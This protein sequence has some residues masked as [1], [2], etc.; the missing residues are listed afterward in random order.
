M[1]PL[2]RISVAI[3]CGWL[4]AIQAMAAQT[5]RVGVYDN[6]PI[7]FRVNENQYAGIGIDVLTD[8]ARQNDWKLEYHYGPWNEVLHLL[9]SG[10][11]DLLI[12][13]AYTPERAKRFNFISE[14]LVNN[15]GVVYQTPGLNLTAMS[16][17]AGKR[18]ALM[19]NSIH[20]QRF[21]ELMHQFGFEY[22]PVLVGHYKDVF[23]AIDQGEAN[24]GVVNRI[25]SI[26]DQ[27]YYD[28]KPTSIMFNPVQVRIAA[29]GQ[30]ESPYLPKINNYLV[31]A[32]SNSDSYYYRVLQN[33]MEKSREEKLPTWLWIVL[34]VAIATLFFVT[35]YSLLVKRQVQLRTREL[36]EVESRFRQLSESVDA[37]FWISSP[38]WHEIFYVSPGYQKIWGVKPE[39]LYKNPDS[40][41]KQIHEQDRSKVQS[42]VQEM[43]NRIT[44]GFTLPEYRVIHRDG[45][46]RWVLAKV[47][48]VHD[49]EGKIIRLAGIC[50]DIT[51]RKQ[52]ADALEYSRTVLKFKNEVLNTVNT[53]ADRVYQS[54]S[55]QD[56]ARA[57]VDSLLQY[58]HSP[59][60]TFY[61]INKE[62]QTLELVH[63]KGFDES[64]LKDAEIIPIDG[65]FSGLCASLK[66]I[67]LSSDITSDQRVDA[68]VKQHLVR[69]GYQSIV[70]VPLLF[71]DEVFGVI[72][73]VF[74]D[75]HQLSRDES[76][77]LMTLGKSVGLAL[78]NTRH[79]QQLVDEK[80]AR[81]KAEQVLID[82][83]KGISTKSGDDFYKALIQQLAAAYNM[84]YAYIG[85]LNENY[86]KVRTIGNVLDGKLIDDFEYALENTPCQKV[87]GED[88]CIYSGNVQQ[89]FP[90]AK[91]LVETGVNSYIG[92]PLINSTGEPLGIIA[93]MDDEVFTNIDQLRNVVIIF[94]YRAASELERQNS[95]R[96]LRESENRYRT[97]IENAPEAIT[98]FNIDRGKFTD[99]NKNAEIF[100]GYD[101]KTLLELN[102][103]EL[104]PKQQPNGKDSSELAHKYITSALHGEVP[105]FEWVHLNSEDKPVNCEIRLVRLPSTQVNEVRGSITDITER[106][107][108]EAALKLS[109]E[110]FER[111]VSGSSDGFWDWPDVSKPDIWWSPRM[112]EM[113]GYQNNE[114]QPT[115]NYFEENLHPEDY[116]RIMKSIQDH[117]QHN[118]PYDVEFR[119]RTR[120]GDYHWY[121]ARGQSLKDETSK[122]ERMSGSMQDVTS[123]KYA[124]QALR[125]SEAR[126]RAIF[127]D[128]GVGIA[129]INSKGELLNCNPAALRI[130]GY[131]EREL[132]NN[133]FA[134]ITHPDDLQKNASRFQQ[135][136]DEEL[137]SY[138]LE[139]RYIRKDKSV[140]EA[141]LI[142]TSIR[143]TERKFRFAIAMI[144]D[145]S[146]RKQSERERM[147]S[148]RRLEA[149][150][151]I[152]EAILKARSPIQTARAA[153]Q[154]LQQLID[155][156]RGSVTLFN[157]DDNVMQL[158]AQTGIELEGLTE[159]QYYETKSHYTSIDTLLNGDVN[160]V[161]DIES[162]SSK[163]K[164]NK[165]MSK[166][167]ILSYFNVPLLVK[168][169]L[170]GAINIAFTRKDAPAKQDLDIVKEVANVLAIAIQQAS[171]LEQVQQHA[172][173]LEARVTERTR[174]LTAT[175]KE[176]ESFSYSVSHDLRAP[177][178]AITGFSQALQE[179]YGSDLDDTGKHYL[180]RIRNAT[181]N[182]SNL[183]DSLLKLSRL[184]RSMYKREKVNLSHLIEELAEEQKQAN[185]DREIVFEI[186][187][188]VIAVCDKN[189]LRVMLSNLLSNA[190]KY[191]RNEPV[192]I[193]RFGARHDKNSKETYFVS[194]NGVGFDMRY[195]DKLF[196]A[197]QRLHSSDSFEGA[198]I[199]LATVQRII[200]RHGG[201]IWAEAAPDEGATFYF[202]L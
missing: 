148:N 68:V 201:R 199:G 33:W 164:I 123:Q 28:V 202:V 83:A 105:V 98:V 17:L 30:I 122:L 121:R 114:F 180:D 154:H 26:L 125:E 62:N 188:D 54:N 150:H 135:L 140:V 109:E 55:I 10:K 200:N 78:A 6:K 44:T 27:D 77:F 97:I 22:T 190:V 128:I 181:D 34:L 75:S 50:Q 21:D 46:I 120:Q 144:E 47:F 129:L 194:D 2:R 187:P 18:I 63:S 160:I 85:V 80:Q 166:A 168:G 152:D 81:D 131:S 132:C 172:Q 66:N 198:G 65:S 99:V 82:V 103:L 89:L 38:D 112:F 45:T 157:I 178:R 169:Q 91:M 106:K 163:A 193:I 189:M 12:G 196:G 113:L 74:H 94:A 111:A 92:V 42:I 185:P 39:V 87:I 48:P 176:L 119:M 195:A 133:T 118:E 4:L 72:S 25:Y 149:L 175:N 192:S 19:E 165:K 90:K 137:D 102:P 100:F 174:E 182:M 156:Q 23:L 9:E 116:Q 56:I 29:P 151:D 93:L 145:I 179:D 186:Q 183:I 142:V 159:K 16:D 60:V 20:S 110:R 13:I 52:A 14:T 108:I 7:V 184:T 8:I 138:Q 147:R 134:E 84:K 73:L 155:Y 59:S 161:N 96:I 95:E 67:L 117:L 115:F 24:A 49:S 58:S 146:L 162:D 64:S 35:L 158:L 170:I 71:N 177:L 143:D 3:L 101:R 86:D 127:D 5:V 173:E 104:S 167:G 53:I 11:I 1:I 76:D 197:F 36:Q 57:T 141:N 88:A 40:W 31:Q 43:R 61:L 130:F 126:F 191:S 124:E 15:W 79:I 139:Q 37:V 69:L 136:L 171:L 70:C 41:L 107:R 51:D 153:L 32:K